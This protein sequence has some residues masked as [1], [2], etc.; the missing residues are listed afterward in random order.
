MTKD[1][2]LLFTAHDMDVVFGLSKRIVVLYYGQF[3][4]DG[5]PE[6]IRTNPKVQEIYLGV[7]D[8]VQHA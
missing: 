4:A 7:E 6:E 2:T 8:E 1:I 5:T 3:I